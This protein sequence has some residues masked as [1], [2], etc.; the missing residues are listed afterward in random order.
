MTSKAE[1]KAKASIKKKQDD[2]TF[3]SGINEPRQPSSRTDNVATDVLTSYDLFGG[4]DYKKGLR[5]PAMSSIIISIQWYWLRLYFY[6]WWL[7]LS[8]V[9]MGIGPAKTN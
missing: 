6:S 5:T 2:C 1:A 9:L 8:I 7:G 4:R 3:T